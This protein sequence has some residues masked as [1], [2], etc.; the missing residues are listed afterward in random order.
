[1]RSN[2]PT[3]NWLKLAG[4]SFDIVVPPKVL[5][6]NNLKGNS[7]NIFESLKYFQNIP[8]N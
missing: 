8:F 4:G 2:T 5:I 1:M 7:K 6:K 3:S